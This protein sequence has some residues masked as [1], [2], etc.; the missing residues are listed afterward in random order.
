TTQPQG[1]NP[2]IQFTQKA[3]SQIQV[4]VAAAP[5]QEDCF[6]AA[7]YYNPVIP[8]VRTQADANNA[9]DG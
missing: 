2:A 6:P 9:L 7:L 3:G 1:I 8:F 4:P 5:F